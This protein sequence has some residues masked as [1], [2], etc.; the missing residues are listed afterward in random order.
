MHAQGYLNNP[1][2][3]AGAIT[4]DGWFKTGDVCIRDEE[5][6][7]TIVD[8]R[9]ELIKYKVSPPS[10]YPLP[11]NTDVRM[12]VSTGFPSPTSRARE[13]VTPERRH[14]RCSRYRD[15]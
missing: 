2:A 6:F 14:R 1:T 5:G 8:R 4:P 13:C 9:K 12:C 10:S 7:Y 11:T 3:T 15:R